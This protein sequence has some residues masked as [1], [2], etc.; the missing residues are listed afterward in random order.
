MG[1]FH[2]RTRGERP[3]VC[4][5]YSV[6]GLS[7]CPMEERSVVDSLPLLYI[8][9][10]GITIRR[11]ERTPKFSNG[12]V[13][14]FGGSSIH[15]L[16]HLSGFDRRAAG[17]NNSS[18]RNSS[19]PTELPTRINSCRAHRVGLFHRKVAPHQHGHRI[20]AIHLLIINY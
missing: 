16:N 10:V 11:L 6:G 13:S 1:P 5:C 2:E 14:G 3:S 7:S 20:V 8:L 17:T 4:P 12:K 18:G 15:L 9:L 19:N